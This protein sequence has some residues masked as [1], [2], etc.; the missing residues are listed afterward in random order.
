MTKRTIILSAIAG[1]CGMAATTQ[2][3]V[4]ANFEAG[5]LNGFG[6]L[7]YSSGVTA[8]A[9]ASPT[10]GEVITP[11]VAGTGSSA[12]QTRVLHFTGSGF[13]G[14]YNSGNGVAI[15]YDFASNG[16]TA[17]FFA[18]NQIEFDWSVPSSTTAAGY[19]Q[20]YQFLLNGG[21]GGG[22]QQFGGSSATANA[23]ATSTGTLNQNPGYT[24]Q[25]N[26][27]VID[28]T[29]YKAQ[30]T[31]TTPGYLQFGIATNNGGGAPADFYFDNFQLTSTPEPTSLAL[32]AVG[33]AGLLARRRRV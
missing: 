28:Y 26:H 27:V 3:A 31:S 21:S 30:F 4:F 11:V 10:A 29:A 9:F 12:L 13:N 6:N 19:S 5:T 14:G 22:F 15:G 23:Y 1:L 2:A 7:T 16:Q 32:A 8:G 17:A 18:N 25:V 33:G 24:G 20:L